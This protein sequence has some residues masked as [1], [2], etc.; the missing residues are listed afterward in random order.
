MPAFLHSESPARK[1]LSASHPYQ[2]LAID[3]RVKRVLRDTP[4]FNGHNDLPQQP[5]AVTYG[6][7]YDQL[8][9]DFEKGFERGMTD[10]LRLRDGD[11]IPP[12]SPNAQFVR[13]EAS[14]V[15][16]NSL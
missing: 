11:L 9:S 12:L 1:A 15:G 16:A 14:S 3:E 4:L 8:K 2:K 6:K 7:I 10:I 5:R 13:L